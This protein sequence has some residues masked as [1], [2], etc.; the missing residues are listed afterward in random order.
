[1]KTYNSAYNLVE[2]NMTLIKDK[3]LSLIITSDG[4]VRF[5]ALGVNLESDKVLPLENITLV[6]SS[7]T[8]DLRISSS[9]KENEGNLLLLPC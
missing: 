3:N 1:M 4:K 8:T 5:E 7:L 2:N 9:V 6:N